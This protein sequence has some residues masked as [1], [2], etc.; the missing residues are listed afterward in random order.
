M[1]K[2]KSPVDLEHSFK[3]RKIVLKANE[4]AVFDDFYADEMKRIF[5]F[6]DIAPATKEDIRV[7]GEDENKKEEVVENKKEKKSETTSKSEKSVKGKKSKK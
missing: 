7:V 4:W 5:P 6:I 3:D 1:K 2:I